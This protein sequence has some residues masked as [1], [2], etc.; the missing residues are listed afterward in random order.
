M[1]KPIQPIISRGRALL[2]AV[3]LISP[4]ATGCAAVALSGA[5]M[6]AGYSFMNVADKTSNYPLDY[7]HLALSQALERM[8]IE[9]TE[10]SET[11]SGREIVAKA[12]DL[13]I[14]IELESITFNT[15][16][17]TVDVSK[18]AILKDRATAVEIIHQT[19]RI[20]EASNYNPEK[21]WRHVIQR[22]I[23]LSGPCEGLEI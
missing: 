12:N 10:D 13:N 17:I 21:N 2:L 15:T 18:A 7:V 20:L 16:R 9:V 5:T 22:C 6:G 19:Q 8:D 23:G 14:D 3:L 4:M 1:N 11:D